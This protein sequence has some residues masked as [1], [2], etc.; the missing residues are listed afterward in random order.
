MLFSFFEKED[1]SDEE[2][3]ML[4]FLE[5]LITPTVIIYAISNNPNSLRILLCERFQRTLFPP[6]EMKAGLTPTYLI[7]FLIDYLPVMELYIKQIRE[8]SKD[9]TKEEKEEL[10]V[11]EIHNNT[12]DIDEKKYTS[13]S[14][15]QNAWQSQWMK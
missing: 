11:K 6:S 15:I 2:I 7:D 10:A 1:I 5:E 12:L 14:C 4:F 3:V 8:L 13:Y 9:F